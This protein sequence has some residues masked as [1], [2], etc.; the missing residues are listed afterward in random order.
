M[1][2]FLKIFTF[3]LAILL[4]LIPISII[5]PYIWKRCYGCAEYFLFCGIMVTS[6]MLPIMCYKWLYSGTGNANYVYNQN[7]A[8][9]M[10]YIIVMPP[11]SPSTPL[12][13]LL[14]RNGT[15]GNFGNVLSL[16]RYR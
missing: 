1:I 16:T 14:T 3:S 6:A 11:T 12:L 8:L 15:L 9:S 13:L 10:L 5:A 2:K 7:L 4:N